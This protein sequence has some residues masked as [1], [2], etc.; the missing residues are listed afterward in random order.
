MKLTVQWMI[1]I[2]IHLF[3]IKMKMAALIK[4]LTYIIY[5]RELGQVLSNSVLA[6]LLYADDV[7]LMANS[8]EDTKVIKL[9]NV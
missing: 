4:S 6:G 5:V 9:M 8:E 2:M 1:I 3:L 7:C